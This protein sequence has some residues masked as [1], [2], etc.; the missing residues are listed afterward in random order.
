MLRTCFNVLLVTIFWV[1]FA[2]A[3]LADRE[4]GETTARQGVVRCGGNNFLRLGGTEIQFASYTLRNF[5]ATQP[6]VVDRMRFFDANGKVLFD[7]AG[8]ALPPAEN[9][10]LGPANNTLNPNQSAQFNTNDILPFLA[11]TDRPIQLEIEWS[12]RG[13]ALGLD[14]ITVRTARQRDPTTGA[15]LAERGGHATGC[16]SIL[17]N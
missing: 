5:D 3:A 12:A 6:I 4:E 13:R 15:M 14:V 7:T 16:R 10:V 11:Q 8:G 1:G 9:G 17:L 2:G